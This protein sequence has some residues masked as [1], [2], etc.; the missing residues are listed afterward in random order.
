MPPRN[1]IFVLAA[2]IGCLAVRVMHDRELPG[3]RFNEV[4][5]LIAG[6]HLEPVDVEDLL[7]AAVAGAVAR[8]DDHSAYLCGAD[9]DAAENRPD[10]L[11]AG[12]GLELVLDGRGD[13]VVA[14]PVVGGPAWAAGLAA[15]DRILAIDGVPTR[16][17]P[18]DDCAARLRGHPGVAVMLRVQ[19]AAAETA[20][21]DPGPVAADAAADPAGTVR[22]VSLVRDVVRIE[23]VLG[24]R[25]RGDG[26]WDWFVEGEPGVAHVRIASFGE[27]TSAELDAALADIAAGPAPRGMILDLRGNAGGLLS[28]A[29]ET[30]DRFLDDGDIVI[31]RRRQDGDGPPGDVRRATNGCLF[32]GVPLAVLIDHLSASSA[33]VVAACLQ[34][35]GRAVIVGRRTYGKGTV[36]TVVPLTHGEGLLKLTS[37]EYLRPSGGRIHR[38]DSAGDDAEWGV[39]PDLGFEVA[40]TGA[41]L[42]RLHAWRRMRDIPRS[43]A[44]AER[45]AAPG[46]SPREIDEV[47]AVG[48]EALRSRGRPDSSA[49]VDLGGEE[50]TARHADEALPAGE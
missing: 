42:E 47:L 2:T 3:R 43:A 9:G 32:P 6:G 27:R 21:L 35:R 39:R 46:S 4:V 13:L 15:G 24:D 45:P 34:D 10:R 11:F 16:H 31:I 36:Q 41:A 25:R 48:L 38:A 37:A 30:C 17:V 33:E 14:G 7:D 8:L 19:R 22:D 23:S 49:T 20:T 28:A 12:V 40:P 18:L 26:S 50:E 44:G 5:S 29:V 1:V